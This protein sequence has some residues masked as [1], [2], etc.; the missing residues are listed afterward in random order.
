METIIALA[1]IVYPPA[2]Q[3]ST[4]PVSIMEHDHP[5]PH[6]HVLYGG[7]LLHCLSPLKFASYCFGASL[8]I[9]FYARLHFMLHTWPHPPDAG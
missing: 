9:A 5:K 4:A 8:C 6:L 1:L 3:L 2:T 7:S